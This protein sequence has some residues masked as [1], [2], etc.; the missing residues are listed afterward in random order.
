MSKKSLQVFEQKDL[1][2]PTLHLS[3]PCHISISLS[4]TR[5]YLTIG[6]RDWE[7]D[8]QTG[9]LIGAGTSL[10]SENR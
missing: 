5:I 6:P 7:W 9:E 10:V 1:I 4:R 3:K 2:L 8:R